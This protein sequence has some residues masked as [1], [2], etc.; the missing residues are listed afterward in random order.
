MFY[1]FLSKG[2]LP[3][4]KVKTDDQKQR[5]V[6]VGK[7]KD[8]TKLNILGYGHPEEF[9]IYMRQV[10]ISIQVIRNCSKTNEKFTLKIMLGEGLLQMYINPIIC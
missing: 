1:Y 10:I 5:Y 7:M 8:A 6:I 2:N 9:E 3:W 4:Q